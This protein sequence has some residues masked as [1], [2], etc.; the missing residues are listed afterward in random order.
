MKGVASIAVIGILSL[1]VA[2][3][4]VASGGINAEKFVNATASPVRQ[5]DM[6]VL[7]LATG[8]HLPLDSDPRAIK[9]FMGAD[10]Q[11]VFVSTENE[12]ILSQITEESV[13][14]PDV[15]SSQKTVKMEYDADTGQKVVVPYNYDSEELRQI[16]QNED[17][18]KAIREKS[19]VD[20]SKYSILNVD[21]GEHV[22]LDSDDQIIDAFQTAAA[23]NDEDLIIVRSTE[24]ETLDLLSHS[25]DVRQQIETL[26]SSEISEAVAKSGMVGQDSVTGESFFTGPQELL[27]D[28]DLV[29]SGSLNAAVEDSLSGIEAVSQARETDLASSVNSGLNLQGMVEGAIQKLMWA[30]A[31]GA[32]IFVLW[33]FVVPYLISY[34]SSKGRGVRHTKEVDSTRGSGSSVSKEKATARGAETLENV[35]VAKPT[36]TLVEMGPDQTIEVT[37]ENVSDVTLKEVEIT[38]DSASEFLG[39]VGAGDEATVRIEIPKVT[40]RTKS[41]KVTV[42]FS[43]VK[44]G[45]RTFKQHKFTVPLKV[46][47]LA[48][49]TE[50]TE[51]PEEMCAFHSDREAVAKCVECGKL[52][53][54]DCAKEKNGKI[55]CPEHA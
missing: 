9:N 51:E 39:T 27:G 43:P 14:D 32:L 37:F 45:A 54:E 41:A 52:L 1:L 3:A 20:T 36:D 24:S 11:K 48:E 55:Y 42:N 19:Q 21:T 16:A 29:S 4:I 40:S 30:G 10:G 31:I 53:C 8:E 13:I 25:Y 26:K 44:I 34:I 47:N 50:D 6:S 35:F 7:N 2:G 49:E 23:A 46:V 5:S 15:M 38:T 22:R 12:T 18:L 33:K 17:V 28:V